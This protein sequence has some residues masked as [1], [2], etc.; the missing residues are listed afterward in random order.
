MLAIVDTVQ[1]KAPLGSVVLAQLSLKAPAVRGHLP[2]PISQARPT[3]SNNTIPIYI[4][5]HRQNPA[6]S[7]FSPRTHGLNPVRATVGLNLINF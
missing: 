1:M 5:P 6:Q 2:Q 7:R 3:G 4:P